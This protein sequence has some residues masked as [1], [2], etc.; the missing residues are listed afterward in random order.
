MGRPIRLN[1]PESQRKPNG[2]SGYGR[3]KFT[4]NRWRNNSDHGGKSL[5]G[6]T[7][8][9][10]NPPGR[11]ERTSGSQNRLTKEQKNKYW[12]AGKCFKCGET[13]HQSRDCPKQNTV[14]ADNSKG[15][16]PPGLVTYNLEFKLGKT[17]SNESDIFEMTVNHIDWFQD[18][19]DMYYS[20]S[21]EGIPELVWVDSSQEESDSDAELLE[22]DETYSGWRSDGIG[23]ENSESKESEESNLSE[24]ESDSERSK[25]NN[26]PIL[27]AGMQWPNFNN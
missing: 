6:R 16:S 9:P 17:E 26:T 3:R 18:I 15:G 2:N 21:S 4:E 22:L 25:S 8:E 24:Y 27:H 7:F 20:D 13:G 12:A 19:E 5:N 10:W 1:Q 11:G 14:K 23:S